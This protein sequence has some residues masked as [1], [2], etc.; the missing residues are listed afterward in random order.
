MERTL[1]KDFIDAFLIGREFDNK[2]TITLLTKL[3]KKDK[4]IEDPIDTLLYC[5]CLNGLKQLLV[6]FLNTYKVKNEHTFGGMI[7]AYKSNN[8]D[9]MIELSKYIDGIFYMNFAPVIK[10]LIFPKYVENFININEVLYSKDI[11][12]DQYFCYQELL[13][14]CIRINDC[15]HVGFICTAMRSKYLKEA[16]RFERDI[17]NIMTYLSSEKYET[18]MEE[19]SKTLTSGNHTDML[20]CLIEQGCH[21]WNV[22]IPLIFKCKFKAIRNINSIDDL[23]YYVMCQIGDYDMTDLYYLEVEHESENTHDINSIEA[24]CHY[25]SSNIGNYDMSDIKHHNI[26]MRPI[27]TNELLILYR[28]AQNKS[29]FDNIDNIGKIR[30]LYEFELARKY[31][32]INLQ[33]PN[34]LAKIIM[35][36]SE[37]GSDNYNFRNI[38]MEITNACLT[39]DFN[40]LGKLLML[41]N[42]EF[43]WFELF[44]KFIKI[45]DDKLYEFIISNCMSQI[46]VT[47]VQP[48][49]DKLPEN[50]GKLFVLYFNA[51]NKVK[52]ENEF[53]ILVSNKLR[54]LYK[55]YLLETYIILYKYH[56]KDVSNLILSYIN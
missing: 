55:R 47:F 7:G 10:E 45:N 12:S 31:D 19:L 9:C 23:C 5:L 50:F 20:V 14:Q 34:V 17:S 11:I 8:I 53:S 43:D 25:I 13:H 26:L 56:C 4:T 51:K 22:I 27:N 35:N 42:F 46:V 52:F 33:F 15:A 32:I 1:V 30:E 38:Y 21:S 54:S 41:S 36:Y 18:L 49:F 37:I 29:I 48:A 6:K 39:H 44:D 16:S 24:W 28:N 3:E 2:E 40:K